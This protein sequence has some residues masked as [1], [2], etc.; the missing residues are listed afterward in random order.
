M[1]NHLFPWLLSLFLLLAIPWRIASAENS[2]TDEWQIVGTGVEYRKYH[3]TTPRPIDLFVTRMDRSNLETTIESSIAQGRNSGGTE[4]VKNMF[5]RYDQAINY[6]GQTWGN[7]N[8][9]VVAINGYFFNESST[10]GEI[11]MPWSGQ[12]HSGWY[13]KRFDDYVGDAGF[14]WSLNREA[15]IGSCVYHITDKQF[16]SFQRDPILP[17]IRGINIER[18]G[19]NLILYTPQFD[20]TTKTSSSPSDP[21]LEIL[22]EMTRPTMILPSPSKAIGYIREIRDQQGSTLIPYDHVVISA[23]GDER[24]SILSRINAGSIAVGDSIGFTQEI[25]DC[26]SSPGNNWT[27]VYAGIAGDYHFLNDGVIRTDFNNP[28][29]GV[30]NSRT[31][32]AYND[33]YV[34][35]IVADRWNPGISEGISIPELGSFV[36]YTLGATDAIA[37]DSGGSSTMVVNG[38]VVNNTTCN[39]TDC[40][41]E[42][43]PIS[44]SE[45]IQVLPDGRYWNIDEGLFGVLS[46]PTA[47]TVEPLV[48][49]GMLMVE[50]DSRRQSDSFQ[51]GG[52]AI[53]MIDTSLRLGPGENYPAIGTAYQD[54][55]GIIQD[56]ENGLNGVLAKGNYWWKVSFGNSVGWVK[57]VRLY[58]SNPVLEADFDAMPTA[59]L[60]PLVVDFSNESI[61]DYTSSNWNFGDG[62]TSTQTNPSHTYTTS[63]IYSVTLTV[64]GPGGLNS[65]TRPNY[66]TIYGPVHAS[67]QA[68]PTIGLLP[69]GVTFTNTSTGIYT[70]SSWNFGDGGTST[71]T[72]PTHNYVSLGT[73]TVS[74]TVAG[75]GGEDQTQGLIFVV[76]QIFQLIFPLMYR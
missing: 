47:A 29:A 33:A 17:R 59:G 61:G 18:N 45:H 19:Q 66:V 10:Q 74:L 62:G 13:A 46:S 31:A 69:L 38:E 65:Y 8:R 30:P 52:Y 12:I 1:K 36:K 26:P 27:K 68:F 44:A 60:E 11:G 7:R 22:V 24:S 63:G 54:A 72:H 37:Q 15:F 25:S 56:P 67:F 6:W 20:S 42:A 43:A 14:A 16:V 5:Y 58:G 57:E 39:F 75:P 23:W 51:P 9:S 28:D 40:R 21:V 55:I 73:Y 49:N 64:S 34:F 41:P 4:T 35:F 3:L 70:S 53:P 32:I 48:G 50:V 76:D 71:L 2:D